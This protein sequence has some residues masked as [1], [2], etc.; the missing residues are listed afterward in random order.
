M[1]EEQKKHNDPGV[2][3]P[4]AHDEEAM[5]TPDTGQASEDD[6]H[7]NLG[8]ILGVL[9]VVLV[10]ILGGLYLWGRALVETPPPS[11]PAVEEVPNN[12]PETPES[13]ARA[14]IAKTQSPSDAFSAIEA[15]IESTNLEAVDEQIDAFTAEFNAQL[16]QSQ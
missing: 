3:A 1:H 4:E 2:D 11:A 8:P 16:Q 9:I 7:A 10:L 14:D 15:D 5:Y 6:A 13:Q 12:E